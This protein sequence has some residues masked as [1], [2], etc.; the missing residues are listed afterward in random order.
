MSE[1]F[2]QVVW[3][4][5]PRDKDDGVRMRLAEWNPD[6]TRTTDLRGYVL[7]KSHRAFG[8]NYGLLLAL[9]L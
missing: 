4:Q 2:G 1:V 5:A 7:R 6:K 8:E 3:L 9:A